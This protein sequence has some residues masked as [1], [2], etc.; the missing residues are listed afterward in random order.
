MWAPTRSMRPRGASPKCGP[1]CASNVSGLARTSIS[2]GGPS[3]CPW[4]WTGARGQG[5]GVAGDV[6]RALLRHSP[7]RRAGDAAADAL[8][9]RFQPRRMARA[10]RTPSPSSRTCG[11]RRSAARSTFGLTYEAQTERRPT[12]AGGLRPRLARTRRGALRLARPNGNG[13]RELDEFVLESSPYEGEYARTFVSTD[14]LL[15]VATIRARARSVSTRRGS[16]LRRS[17]ARVLAPRHPRRRRAEH[18]ARR[19]APLPA[20]PAPLPRA[21]PDRSAGA[22]APRTD[23]SLWRG[24]PRAAA[25]TSA[26][27]SR[28]RR[29]PLER[30]ERRRLRTLR[31]EG[32]YRPSDA[33]T[34]RVV[35]TDEANTAESDRFASRRYRIDG[36]GAS[37]PRSAG[38]RARSIALQRRRRRVPPHRP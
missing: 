9:R 15:G 29:R 19:V 23:L 30:H 8:P 24:A 34:A 1:A 22:S 4:R 3:G 2:S 25:S 26:P 17:C 16:A 33:L 14:R 20:R 13:A 21:R 11:G 31:A 32:R 36:R 7:R 28:A 10:I 27:P 5:G 37:T 6:G 12:A 35:L 18:R 38:S